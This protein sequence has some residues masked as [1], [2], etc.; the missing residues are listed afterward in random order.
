MKNIII[1]LILSLLTVQSAEI[2]FADDILQIKQTGKNKYFIQKGYAEVML[3]LQFIVDGKTIP[4]A[5]VQWRILDA[6]NYSAAMPFD[7]K[8]SIAGLSFGGAAIGNVDAV[9]IHQDLTDNEGISE[10]VLTDIIGERSAYIEAQTTYE[11][12]LYTGKCSVVFGKGP[13]SLFASPPVG[14]LSWLELYK[15]CNKETY[16]GD[17][18]RWKVGQDDAGGAKIPSMPQ[19]QSISLPGEYNKAINAN[20]AAVAAGWPS[21]HRYWNGRVVMKMRASHVD[22]QNGN[23]HGSGGNNV[24]ESE[25]GVC[26]K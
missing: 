4:D 6:D 16:N 14:P 26:L 7:Q 23:P 18:S 17:P 3:V 15:K 22:I 10:V 21:D 9:L 1:M 12:K 11:G 25:Y 24:H 13:L 19:M 20:G 8:D 5:A 2:C